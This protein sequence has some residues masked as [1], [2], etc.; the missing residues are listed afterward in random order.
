MRLNPPCLGYGVPHTGAPIGTYARLAKAEGFEYSL[1]G[2]M[3]AGAQP[4]LQHFI[5]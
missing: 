3:S 5:G 4:A 1:H 2:S